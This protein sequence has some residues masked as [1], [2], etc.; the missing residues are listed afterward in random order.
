MY[1][2]I[3]N[4]EDEAADVIARL[5]EHAESLRDVMSRID[6]FRAYYLLDTGDGG[7]AT[8]SI[9]AERAG[10]EESTRAAGKWLRETGLIDALPNPPT[11]LQGDVAITVAR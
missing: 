4:Y 9:Y 8:V 2:V 10:A 7:V 11:I 6:G 3:R 5:G 1:A